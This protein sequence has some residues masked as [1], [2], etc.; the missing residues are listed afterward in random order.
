MVDKKKPE[1]DTAQILRQS[2][3]L[4]GQTTQSSL[5]K[6]LQKKF[7]EMAERAEVD[8][9]QN[10]QLFEAL[11]NVEK[12]LL[13]RVERKLKIAERMREI[14]MNESSIQQFEPSSDELSQ[15]ARITEQ[16]SNIFDGLGPDGVPPTEPEPIVI[17]DAD[18]PNNQIQLQQEEFT[19]LLEDPTKQRTIFN[20]LVR[21]GKGDIANDFSQLM[22]DNMQGILTNRV[23]GPLST[24]TEE[25]ITG[26]PAVEPV[27]NPLAVGSED[28]FSNIRR[29]IRSVTGSAQDVVQTTS[30]ALRREVN[31]RF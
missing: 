18:D 7:P 31:R 23:R 19:Q 9:D 27:E 14:G 6:R 17:G 1:T 25:E 12:E 8:L 29:N 16:K 11:G 26:Q 13:D 22:A 21:L 10:A 2:N 20:S 30:T 4:K 15:L 3:F 5:F 28:P 24:P